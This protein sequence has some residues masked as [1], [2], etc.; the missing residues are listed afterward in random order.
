MG[1]DRKAVTPARKLREE[2]HA[3][4]DLKF[5]RCRVA[6]ERARG[7]ALPATAVEAVGSRAYE[8]AR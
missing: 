6:R 1:R 8:S 3:G 5:A 7:H 4:V 2:A